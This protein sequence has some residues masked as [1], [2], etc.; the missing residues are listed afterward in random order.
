VVAVVDPNTYSSGDL[1]AAGFVDNEVGPLVC[2]G[3]A[4]GAGGANVWTGAQLRDALAG[5]PYAYPTL[6]AGIGFT[7]SVRRAIRSGAADGVP[8][9]DLGVGGIPYTMTRRDLLDGNRDLLEFCGNL[10]ASQRPTS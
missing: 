4:T 1:F 6:P 5:T 10:L 3:E 8:I 9:E 7:L 2:V